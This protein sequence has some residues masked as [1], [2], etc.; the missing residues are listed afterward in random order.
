MNEAKAS[1]KKKEETPS[2][3]TDIKTLELK[4]NY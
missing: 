3:I 1:L 4:S 2:K